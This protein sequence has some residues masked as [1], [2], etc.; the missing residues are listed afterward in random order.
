MKRS[1]Y[2]GEGYLFSDD[3]CSDGP[4][5]EASILGCSHCQKLMKKKDWQAD[6]GFC[7]SCD[8]P[9]CSHCADRILKHGCE[10]FMRALETALMKQY[11]LEQNARLMGLDL[12]ERTE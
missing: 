3:R 1:I 9:V 11:R 12:T 5:E 2:S 8:A 6:G 4:F 7:H 10:V